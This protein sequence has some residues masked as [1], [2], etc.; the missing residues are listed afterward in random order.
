MLM[1]KKLTIVIA[2][3][4]CLGFAAFTAHAIQDVVISHTT[5]EFD[6]HTESWAFYDCPPFP[7]EDEYNRND[8]IYNV[9][10][11]EIDSYYNGDAWIVTYNITTQITRTHYEHFLRYQTWMR[12]S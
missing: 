12:R 6:N 4:L 5:V 8:V 3:L 1:N 9:Q 10:R 7:L 11:E 2:T